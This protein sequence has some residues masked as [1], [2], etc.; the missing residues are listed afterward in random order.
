MSVAMCADGREFG[1]GGR[2][3]GRGGGHCCDDRGWVR[4]RVIRRRDTPSPLDLRKVF[5]TKELGVDFDFKVLIIKGL[6]LA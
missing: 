5:A 1:L 6:G 4:L 3:D 2:R